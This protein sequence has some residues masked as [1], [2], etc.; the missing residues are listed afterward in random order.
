M[1]ASLRKGYSCLA[2]G[3]EFPV[4]PKSAKIFPSWRNMK[5]E[6]I[7]FTEE[8][9][10]EAAKLLAQRHQQNRRLLPEL[11]A[12]FEDPD[13]AAKAIETLWNKTT[14]DLPRCRMENLLPI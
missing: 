2:H 13:V 11:P 3:T 9:L 10:P 7:S 14:V 4:R 8:L 1:E 12:R 6:L 5:T